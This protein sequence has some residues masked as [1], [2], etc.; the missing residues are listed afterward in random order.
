MTESP[1]GTLGANELDSNADTCCLGCNFVIMNYTNRQADVYAYDSKHAPVTNIP[2]VSGATAWTNPNTRETILLIFHESLFFGSSLDH[3]LLNPNQI[4]HNCIDFWDNPYDPAH[5]LSIVIDGEIIIPLQFQGTKLIF[6]SRTPTMQELDTCRQVEMTS[7]IPWEPHEVHLGQVTRQTNKRN[8]LF[9]QIN[10]AKTYA[11]EDKT[12]AYYDTKRDEA[13]LHS[14]E[15]SLVAL[16]EMATT[17]YDNNTLDI[18]IRR[19][20]VSGDRHT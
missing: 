15:P 3:S 4:R 10:E 16:K 11:Y 13:I 9:V 6:N 19:T 7:V 2:I 17:H 5:E 14:I 20:F 8:N 1:A 18:P 12:Y